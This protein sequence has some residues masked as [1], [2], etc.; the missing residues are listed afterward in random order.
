MSYCL[1][2]VGVLYLLLLLPAISHGGPSLKVMYAVNCGGEA[3]TDSNGFTYKRD[4]LMG[5]IGTA[6]DYGKQLD[7]Q[8]APLLDK[9]LY[10]TE[11]YHHSTFGYDIPVVE[12]GDYVLILKFSEVYF[13]APN[14]KVFD[15]VLNGDHTVVQDLDIYQRVGRGVAHD[16][17]VPLSIQ[18]GRL[19]YRG[20]ESDIQ[21]GKIRVE[22]IKGYRDN[23]KVNAILLLKG[24][25]E[26]VPLL[27]PLPD[28][29]SAQPPEE[30]AAAAEDPAP[31]RPSKASSRPSGPRT[32]DPYS[33][34]ETSTMLPLFVAIGA[35]IPVLLCLCKL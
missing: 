9:P 12:D 25:L 29:A 20:D 1:I 18:S 4:P 6:S 22:F 35:F 23:P 26:D 24:N 8:R 2:E 3:H 15:V 13:D 17:V 10:Q 21:G 34:D 11:R 30:E 19:S 31:P 33:S 5:K 14:M 28:L 7:I 27:P 16:E 32:P